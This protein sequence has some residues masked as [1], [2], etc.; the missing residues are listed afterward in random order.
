MNSYKLALKKIESLTEASFHDAPLAVILV[1]TM[2]FRVFSRLL[3]R[4][5]T[6]Y[7][8]NDRLC[9]K[10]PRKF[11]EGSFFQLFPDEFLRVKFADPH[12]ENGCPVS[13]QWFN[14]LN[15]EKSSDQVYVGSIFAV[16]AR[17]LVL[18][19]PSEWEFLRSEAFLS[20]KRTINEHIC[21]ERIGHRSQAEPQD[22]CCISTDRDSKSDEGETPQESK[23]EKLSLES[24]FPGSRENTPLHEDKARQ[25]L[26]SPLTVLTRPLQVPVTTPRNLSDL[27]CQFLWY[28]GKFGSAYKKR[29]VI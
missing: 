18:R 3:D 4:E 5:K 12:D 6:C 1:T 21:F 22:L 27:Y 8:L 24:S 11:S 25:N 10:Q 16:V 13:S 28:Y 17:N 19:N 20:L 9:G 2:L 14:L 23:G 15:G 7:V 29:V 26:R